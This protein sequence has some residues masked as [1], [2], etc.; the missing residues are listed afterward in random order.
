MHILLVADGRSPITQRWIETV[1]ALNHRI[2]LLSTYP[3]EPLKQIDHFCILPVAFSRLASRQGGS[4]AA[5][6]KT[7]ASQRQHLISSSKT[8]FLKTR[9]LF[10]PFSVWA[11]APRF[12]RFLNSCQ[13]D[14]VHALRIPYEGMLAS[15]TPKGTP[16]AVTIWGNDLTLHAPASRGIGYCTR[17]VLQRADGLLT[18]VQRDQRLARQ[19]GFPADRPAEVVPGNGGI[20]L[21]KLK[22]EIQPLPQELEALIPAGLPLVVNPRGIRAYA[23]SDTFFQS[24]PLVLERCPEIGFICPG[25]QAQPQ[26]LGWMQRLKLDQ[27]TVLLPNLPQG[28]LWGL[29]QRAFASVSITTHDGTPNTLLEAMSCNSLPIAGDIESLREWIDP[30]ING[31]LVDP[32]DPAALADAI[33]YAH[34]HPDFCSSA[35]SKNLTIIAER[36]EVR[37]IRLVI[38]RFYKSLLGIG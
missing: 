14:L 8:V 36:A 9:Y 35:A 29:F 38:D 13:P 6:S 22:S 25:M 23:R 12:R 1:R 5:T 31:L 20:D 21:V 7:S 4:A 32:S 19:W 34:N 11:A 28:Q 17:R 26:A 30:G 2:S 18:D 33:I 24:I 37:A 27:R 15:F 3:C 10:G 16:L